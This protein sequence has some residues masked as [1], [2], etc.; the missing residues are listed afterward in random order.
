MEKTQIIIKGKKIPLVVRNFKTSRSIKAYYKGDILYIS[1]P[2]RVSLREIDKFIDKY[3]TYLYAEYVKIKSDKNLGIK[4]WVNGEKISY[5]GKKY[6]IITDITKKK[7]VEIKI[8]ERDK[9]FYINTP[10]G[11][12]KEERTEAVLKAIKKEFKKNTEQIIEDKL[13]YWSFVTGIEYNS[14]KV[15]DATTRYGSCV[16]SRKSLNFSSR[17][18]MLPSRIIDAIVVHELCH[19]EQANHGPKFYGL[20]EKYMPDYKEADKW[21]KENNNLLNL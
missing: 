8:N 15:H 9:I 20:V 2:S 12:V 14:F 16:K 4:R 7:T 1:K 6:T 18:V 10:Q 11:L 17:L 19:I 13:N 3:Q 21:L 5:K